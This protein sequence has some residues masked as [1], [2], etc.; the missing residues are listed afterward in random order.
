[1]SLVQRSG[2]FHQ[3]NVNDGTFRQTQSAP[4]FMGRVYLAGIGR[5]HSK[6]FR[7]TALIRSIFVN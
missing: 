1:M 7:R 4:R 6:S 2:D 5:Q 3:M